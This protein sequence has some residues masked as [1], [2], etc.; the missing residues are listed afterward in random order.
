MLQIGT[1]EDEEKKYASL[2]AGQSIETI[3]LEEALQAFALPR[4]VGAYQGEKVL[5]N[6]GR[7]GP[8][9][10]WGSLFVSIK[11]D[12]EF[13]LFSITLEQAIELIEEKK[14]ADANKY[15]HRFPYE[16]EEIQVLNGMYGPY[17]KYGKKNYKIPKG[18]KDA[19]D[20]TLEDALAIIGSDIKG[21]KAL[22]KTAKKEVKKT[23]RTAS[24][25]KK[26]E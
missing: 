15:I 26:K 16:G 12:A 1:P 14:K 13:D 25:K 24:A 17:V 7:F 10:K 11:K 22:T 8:Y 5:A 19:T 21:G 4:E 23:P 20:F 18:G 3:G 9:V 2:P 6:N